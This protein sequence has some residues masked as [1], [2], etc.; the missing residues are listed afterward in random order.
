MS[1]KKNPHYEGMQV[2]LEKQGDGLWSL[3]SILDGQVSSQ[4]SFPADEATAMSRATT[5]A[6][7][8][9]AELVVKNVGA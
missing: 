5:L 7:W 3:F 2:V 8:F 1:E 9:D 6:S 4:S